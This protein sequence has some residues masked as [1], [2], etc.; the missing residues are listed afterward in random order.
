[1][2]HGISVKFLSLSL[3]EQESLIMQSSPPFNNTWINP[4]YN[5]VEAT[6]E[7]VSRLCAIEEVPSTHQQCIIVSK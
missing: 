1:M 7:G 2:S 3:S 5:Q 4:S 6:C